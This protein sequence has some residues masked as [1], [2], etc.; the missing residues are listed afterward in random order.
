MNIL[1]N[2]YEKEKYA[3]IWTTTRYSPMKG[4][5]SM[6]P[7][8]EEI[9]IQVQLIGSR[10]HLIWILSISIDVYAKALQLIFVLGQ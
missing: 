7:P 10:L 3:S 4:I 8:F 2:K 5:I 9:Y 1:E 6:V